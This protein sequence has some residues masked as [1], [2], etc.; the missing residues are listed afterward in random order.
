[1]LARMNRRFI[2]AYWDDY[3][4][5][6]FFNNNNL[7][8]PNRT[9]PAVNVVEEDKAYRIEVAAPG[10]KKED[11]RID[12]ENDVLTVS[13]ETKAEKKDSKHNYMRREFSY[14]G[15]KRSFQL[16]DTIDTEKITARVDSGIL[17]IQLS[18]RGE[19]IQKAP[20]QIEIK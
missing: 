10:L 16:P 11:F 14:S 8:A 5:D 3:F 18:K 13:S 7:T 9:S 2:P 1:M 12:L 20:K 4:N 19:M 15:F 17:S 6:A